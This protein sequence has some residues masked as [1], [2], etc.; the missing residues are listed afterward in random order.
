MFKI[1]ALVF[2]LSIFSIPAHLAFADTENAKQIKVLKKEI[3]VNK[4]KINRLKS[5]RKKGSKQG[6]CNTGACIG[7][8]NNYCKGQVPE[9]PRDDICYRIYKSSCYSSLT[10]SQKEKIN[11]CWRVE[12]EIELKDLVDENKQ[13]KADLEAYGDS[14]AKSQFESNMENLNDCPNCKPSKRIR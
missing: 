9:S 14:H 1:A 8:A 7:I 2:C 11:K 13:L 12:N 3:S 5:A 10:D 4:K 6:D